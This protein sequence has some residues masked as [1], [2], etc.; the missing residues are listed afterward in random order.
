[1]DTTTTPIPQVKR[2]PKEKKQIIDSVIDLAAGRHGGKVDVSNIVEEPHFL[3]R[4][5]VV[6][7]LLEFKHDPV[8]H[9][10]PTKITAEGTFFCAAPPGLAPELADLFMTPINGPTKRRANAAAGKENKKRRVDGSVVDDDED[11]EQPRR[12]ES[13]A[14]SLHGGSDIMGRDSMM[15]DFGPVDDNF[16]LQAPDFEPGQADMTLD[17]RQ[18]SLAPSTLS[19]LSTPGPLD[20]DLPRDESSAIATFDSRQT[21]GE[22]DPADATGKGY[23][24]NTVKALGILRHELKPSEEDEAAEKVVSFKNLSDKVRS[25]SYPVR[26]GS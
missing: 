22:S 14:A 6:M 9:F 20:E 17:E 8:G 12:A 2:K 23:S 3:P 15:P 13:V 19:R 18:R 5:T 26:C 16:E 25:S 24:R 11:V 7:R 1:M 21:Q 4:S 10:L